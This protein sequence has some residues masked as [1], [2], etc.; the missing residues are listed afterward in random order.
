MRKIW[1]ECLIYSVIV[2]Y[3]QMYHES[4][5]FMTI[6]QQLNYHLEDKEIFFNLKHLIYW[7]LYHD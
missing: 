6:P 5:M 4:F 3:L 2:D 7:E 1:I